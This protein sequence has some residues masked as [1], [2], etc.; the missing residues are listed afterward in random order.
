MNTLSE[1]VGLSNIEP[2]DVVSTLSDTSGAS[3]RKTVELMLTL[4][5]TDGASDADRVAGGG[6]P[7]ASGGGPVQRHGDVWPDERGQ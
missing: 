7:D 1:N 5:E 3:V 2:I 4:S 6:V